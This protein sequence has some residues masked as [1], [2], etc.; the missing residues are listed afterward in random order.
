MK[1]IKWLEKIV[2]VVLMASA[3]VVLSRDA[4]AQFNTPTLAGGPDMYLSPLAAPCVPFQMGP[5]SGT[6]EVLIRSSFTS[7][8][9]SVSQGVFS[10]SGNPSNTLAC[11]GWINWIILSSGTTY[12]GD[13]LI[14]LDTGT[15]GNA[16]GTGAYNARNRILPNLM[17]WSTTTANGG[18]TLG[19]GNIGGMQ[20]NLYTF[21]PPLRFTN[22]LTAI[23]TNSLLGVGGTGT[24][25][26][27][28][29]S[30]CIANQ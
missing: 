17:Y 16:P 5:S 9:V 3:Y 1:S 8:G 18:S 29:R 26:I 22:G 21:S 20:S 4:Q 13:F 24:A 7:A 11:S 27:C 30:S 23:S 14:L 19:A 25:T 15:L 12:G 10:A 6:A 2:V 28:Y